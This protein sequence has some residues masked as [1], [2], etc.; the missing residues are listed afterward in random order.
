MA[1]PLR[2]RPLRLLTVHYRRAA[3]TKRFIAEIPELKKAA[4]QAAFFQ[5]CDL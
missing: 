1:G 5:V 2:V 3:R 4:L